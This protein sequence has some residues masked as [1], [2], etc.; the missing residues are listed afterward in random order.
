MQ[1]T[2]NGVARVPEELWTL[3]GM[4]AELCKAPANEHRLAILHVL[5]PGE[6]CVGDLAVA[7]G[8]PIHKVSQ[9]L[10]V[11][12]ERML[13][14]PCQEGDT[15]YYSITA[16][17]FIEGCTPIR[18]ALIEQHQAA[19]RSLRAAELPDTLRPPRA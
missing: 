12:K 4:R 10:R 2:D 7:L 8:I 18:Q 6:M 13:V 17:R 1:V 16:P 3:F 11:L 14:R 15:V 9:H 5:G 19:R